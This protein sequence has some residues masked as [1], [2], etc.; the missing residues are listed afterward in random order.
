MIRSFL[1]S[2]AQRACSAS[3]PIALA[4]TRRRSSVRSASPLMSMSYTSRNLNSPVRRSWAADHVAVADELEV[5]GNRQPVRVVADVRDEADRAAQQRDEHAP[6]ARER[7]LRAAR[8]V[9]PVRRAQ[10]ALAEDLLDL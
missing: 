2:P 4:S 7:D 9:E 10:Q 6:L 8:V 1:R 3:I 5:V